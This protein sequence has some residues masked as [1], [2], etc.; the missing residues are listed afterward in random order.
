MTNPD[1]LAAWDWTEYQCQC[2]HHAQE[3][4][5]V[6]QFKVAIHGLAACNEPGLDPDGNRIEIR[7]AECVNKMLSAVSS[8]LRALKKRT[9]WGLMQCTTCGSPVNQ[10]GDIVRWVRPLTGW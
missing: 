1:D 8:K 6:A 2:S 3:C 9:N 4:T 7:C 10:L 5:P